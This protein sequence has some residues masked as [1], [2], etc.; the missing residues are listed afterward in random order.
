M[1]KEKKRLDLKS[2]NDFQVMRRTFRVELGTYEAQK[3]NFSSFETFS[4]VGTVGRHL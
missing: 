4:C 1:A 2:S 3:T